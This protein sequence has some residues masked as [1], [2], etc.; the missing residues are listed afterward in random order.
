MVVGTL[1]EERFGIFGSEYPTERSSSSEKI[2]GYHYLTAVF[3]HSVGGGTRINHAYNFFGHALSIF[4][5]FPSARTDRLPGCR[6]FHR[7]AH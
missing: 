3:S 2:L 7:L 1:G 5:P 6:A 4:H